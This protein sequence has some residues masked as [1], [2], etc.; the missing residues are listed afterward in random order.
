MSWRGWGCANANNRDTMSEGHLP[1]CL[2]P[3]GTHHHHEATASNDDND[4]AKLGGSP[5]RLTPHRTRA[6]H[7]A[8][9]VENDNAKSGRVQELLPLPQLAP[10]Y[11]RSHQEAPADADKSTLS[12]EN[13]GDHHEALM[14][15]AS[16]HE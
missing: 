2:N 8:P 10:G 11:T 14:K 1:S 6:H 5:S 13:T 9:E 3:H 16:T 7:K 15:T 4:Y 12:P